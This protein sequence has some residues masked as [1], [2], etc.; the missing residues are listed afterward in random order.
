[1]DVLSLGG[2]MGERLKEPQTIRELAYRQC[3]GMDIRMYRDKS[4][5]TVSVAVHD[6]KLDE[7]FEV[8]V[9][10]GDRAL[11]VFHHPHAYRAATARAAQKQQE[12]AAEDARY[13]LGNVAIEAGL[14][15]KT[16]LSESI[17]PGQ[18]A[19]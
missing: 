1:M 2:N 10:P 13:E 16:N 12:R 7:A 19:A 11:D 8:P 6:N 5:N 9:G 3:D 14:R 17:F 4:A 18:E 15:G